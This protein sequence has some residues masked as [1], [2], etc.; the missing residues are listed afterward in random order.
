MLRSV[1]ISVV[2]VLVGAACG[3]DMVEPSVSFVGDNCSSSDPGKWPTGPLDIEVSNSTETSAAVVMGTYQDGFG[4]DDLV[5]YGSDVS[6]RPDF[7]D[8]LEIFE[9]APEST[10]SLFFD[11]GPGTYFMACMPDN[12]TMVVLDDVTI[13]G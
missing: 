6:S 5:A 3:D 8:A 11:H 12:N 1:A 9:T 4:H 2:V 13:E 10:S 7:I